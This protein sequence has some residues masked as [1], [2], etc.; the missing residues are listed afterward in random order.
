MIKRVISA[1]LPWAAAVMFASALP[2]LA[3]ES[4]K[5][6]EAKRKDLV[7]QGDA[8]CT[9]CHDESEAFPVLAIGKT[10]H[11]TI[12][13]ARSGSC[14]SCHGASPT[15]VDK[16]SGVKVRPQPDVVFG[17]KSKTPVVEQNATCLTCHKGGKLMLWAA[18]AHDTKEVAC[19]SCHKL[20][21]QQ[22]KVM[23]RA[24]QPET[25]FT[26]HKEQR[27]MVSRPSHHPIKE[28]K[29]VCSDCHNS[30]GSAGPKL[31]VKDSVVNTCYTCHM[32]KRGPFVWNHQPVTEDCSICHNPH[33]SV[34]DK[35]LKARA[36]FLCQQ[37]HERSNH[38]GSIPTTT[39]ANAFGAGLTLG[40]GCVNC[41]SNI[42]GGSSPTNVSRNRA[43]VR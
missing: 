10:K 16:P 21:A 39:G 19:A 18:S 30:H 14:V 9:R 12:A 11:G 17:K 15:H 13:D 1:V 31:M 5:D 28:G 38:Q 26:C 4:A 29:V 35:L 22:D 37:C 42:H 36:P 40:R 20:H 6:G 23:D 3:E 25:C 2:A 33:G 41:H 32:E 8:V 27:V 43:F 24:T 34:I 7:Q